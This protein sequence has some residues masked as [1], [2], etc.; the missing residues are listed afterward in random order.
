M[1]Q[2]AYDIRKL[3]EQK[4]KVEQN[5]ENLTIETI[6]KVTDT[7]NRDAER[8]QKCVQKQKNLST[9]V[10]ILRTDIEQKTETCQRSTL[11]I[12][13]K[14]NEKHLHKLK[15]DLKELKEDSKISR[16]SIQ[17]KTAGLMDESLGLENQYFFCIE[18]PE[19][20]LGKS[21]NKKTA[22]FEYE[23]TPKRKENKTL[24]CS[25]LCIPSENHLLVADY[26]NSAILYFQNLQD[27]K[28]SF[29][30][31]KMSSGPWDMTATDENK[32]AVTFPDQGQFKI[33][34]ISKLKHRR[35]SP[36]KPLL[37]SEEILAEIK[38]GKSCH[39]I[40]NCEGTLIVSYI[41]PAK[42]QIMDMNGYILKTFDK[43][44]TNKPLFSSP[45][46]IALDTENTIL[47][48]SD[49][50]K[51]TI[52]GMTIDGKVKSI[53]KPKPLFRPTQIATD[54]SGT[55]FV[56]GH[57]SN[58]I[59]VLSSEKL[60]MDILVQGRGI[61]QPTSLAYCKTNNKLFVGMTTSQVIRVFKIS[62]DK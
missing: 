23:I 13:I 27:N 62:T 49:S 17:T 47:Y 48:V 58:N 7:K 6:M 40:T 60:H 33:I 21:E 30:L 35:L 5:L 22:T 61:L 11:F 1:K 3:H 46:H 10:K 38:V 37:K 59:H 44:Y 9:D 54:G 57:K 20:G 45:M 32:V 25:S 29:T 31:H 41:N 51:N 52:T 24:S 16:Y 39:G 43:D 50:E 12:A 56:C 2:R 15:E 19:S 26:N 53:Y 42:I 14:K 8:L 4:R 28:D 36:L 18:I 55:P 34:N